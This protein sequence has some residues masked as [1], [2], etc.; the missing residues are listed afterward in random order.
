MALA[1][2]PLATILAEPVVPYE[3]DEVTRLIVDSH[4]I[5]AFAPV[6][7][8]TVGEFREFLLAAE[9]QR[10]PHSA[11]VSRRRWPPPSAS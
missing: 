9:P 4:D 1:D 6:A 3:N 10:S 5:V 11:P 8:L 7:T 2:V